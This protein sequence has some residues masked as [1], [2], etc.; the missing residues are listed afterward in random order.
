MKGRNYRLKGERDV[1]R[2]MAGR[3]DNLEYYYSTGGQSAKN[4]Y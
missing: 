1:F 3:N 4:K 2:A